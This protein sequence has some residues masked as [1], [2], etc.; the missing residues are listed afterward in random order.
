M[1]EWYAL[2]AYLRSFGEEGLPGRYAAPDGRKQV[3]T[4]WN[5]IEL[6][7]SPGAPTL[8]ALVVLVLAAALAAV[9]VRWV[10][11]SRRRRRYG[12]RRWLWRR[13]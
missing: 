9:L 3:S 1:K 6:L 12:G 7:Q 11:G 13:R 5:P 4:S 8:I 10:L 2:A